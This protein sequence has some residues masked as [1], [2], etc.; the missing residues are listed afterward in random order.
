MIKK[1]QLLLVTISLNWILLGCFNSKI[2]Q[3]NKII[4]ISTELAQITEPNLEID[5][6]NQ[7]LEIANSFDD[8]AQAILNQKISDEQL[9][10]YSQD[11]ANI[12]QNYA[13]LTRNFVTAFQNKDTEN[14]IFYKEELFNLS[15][16]QKN[17][18]N[19]INTYC[20]EN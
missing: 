20:Q 9:S 14:A 8:S 15:Q 11:L 12:Y 7:I 2:N 3:C 19:T 17:L 13:Q 1:S 5:E 10:L 18:V 16:N 4:N 6:P